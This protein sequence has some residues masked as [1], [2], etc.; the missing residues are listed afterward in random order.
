MFLEKCSYDLTKYNDD[1]TWSYK[2]SDDDEDD[3]DE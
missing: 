1:K 2:S 3:V